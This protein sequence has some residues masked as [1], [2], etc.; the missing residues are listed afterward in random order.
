MG[1]KQ[2]ASDNQR[3]EEEGGKAGVGAGGLMAKFTRHVVSMPSFQY[4]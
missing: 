2:D 1:F 3:V 4:Q